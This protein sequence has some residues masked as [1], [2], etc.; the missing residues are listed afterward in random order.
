MW[1][2]RYRGNDGPSIQNALMGEET[3][4]PWHWVD[5]CV[6]C[7][8]VHL[9]CWL[10]DGCQAH[11]ETCATCPKRFSTETREGRCR[12]NGLTGVQLEMT[13]NVKVGSKYDFSDCCSLGEKCIEMKKRH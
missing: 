9:H 5:E 8:S 12:G 1:Q 11:K 6:L 4:R 7:P 13:I 3:M 2:V 10:G